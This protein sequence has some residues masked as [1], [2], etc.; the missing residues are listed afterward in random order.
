MVVSTAWFVADQVMVFETVF[1]HPSFSNRS[2]LICSSS[3]E[4][5]DMSLIKPF[6]DSLA[7]AWDRFGNSHPVWVFIQNVFADHTVYVYDVVFLLTG[8]SAMILVC[9]ADF[10]SSCSDAQKLNQVLL[11]KETFLTIFVCVGL[12]VRATRFEPLLCVCPL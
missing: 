5:D 9:R 3:K 7:R 10:S 11:P 2:M 12:V 1:S 8:R 4:T 6:V